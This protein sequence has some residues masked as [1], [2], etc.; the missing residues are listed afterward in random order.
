[1]KLLFKLVFLGV[2]FF[3]IGCHRKEAGSKD[4]D[5]LVKSLEKAIRDESWNG[6][7]RLVI[8]IEDATSTDAAIIF[9]PSKGRLVSR[10]CHSLRIAQ[11][12][13]PD[14]PKFIES[15][16]PDD[17]I[18]CLVWSYPTQ[19]GNANLEQY[20]YLKK[21]ENRYFIVLAKK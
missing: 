15:E 16:K 2:L 7:S 6:I 3:L 18:L 9:A 13:W 21:N 14:M 19:H 17:L 20:Y 4:I 8:N 12:K 11:K 10:E 5:S 1:M